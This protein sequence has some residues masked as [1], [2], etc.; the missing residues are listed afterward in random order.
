MQTLV[1]GEEMRLLDQNTIQHMEVPSLV[2][3]ERAALA[4]FDCL[5][6]H[7]SLKRTLVLCG[8]GNNG[9]DGMAVARLLHLAG[10]PV[11]LY[12][13]GSETSFSKEAKQQWKIAQN[14][15]VSIV[16]NFCLSEYTSIVDALFGVGLSR[17][18]NDSYQALLQQVNDSRIPVLSVDIP[19]GI[20]AGTGQ[21][22]GAAV[23]A[24]RTV[25]FAYRKLGISLNPGS[26]YAGTIQIAD[27]GIYGAKEGVKALEKSDFSMLPKRSK[28]GNKGTFG[29]V[30]VIAGS[31]NMSGAAYFSSKA[32]LLSGAGMVR[33]LTENSNRLILQQQFP[34]A[35]LTTYDLQ[36]DRDTLEEIVKTA[37]D[38]ADVAAIGP[39][40]GT[41]PT[42]QNLLE[43]LL[44]IHDG[45]PIVVDADALNL[46]SK[47]DNLQK[48]CSSNCI[49]TPHLGEMA[50]LSGHSIDAILQAP[51]ECMEEFSKQCP[52]NLVMK[53][54][55]TWVH[56]WDDR[57]YLNLTGNHGMATAGSGDVLCGIITGLLAQGMKPEEAAPFGVWIHGLA[58]DQAAK[59]KGYRAMIASDLLDGLCTQLKEIED[60]TY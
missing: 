54:A 50:R 31:P 18:L 23:Q 30:L 43:I 15:G 55:R 13:A 56:T 51:M 33:I 10:Y 46:L 44:T 52:A 4:V 8:S 28:N 47:N 2:L 58:G 38:W 37:L 49:L 25:T 27:I 29:K 36:S 39:G 34:E 53:D 11:D 7:F 9:A 26:L 42:A 19:S 32:A 1:T 45:K 22:M 3:M 20:H 21:V 6:E 41:S 14:Y 35:M 17:N 16:N 12:L 59:K 60:Q 40:L 5:K 57:H 48:L 24:E